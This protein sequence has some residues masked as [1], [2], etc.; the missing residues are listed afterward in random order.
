MGRRWGCVMLTQEFRMYAEQCRR[1]AE[2]VRTEEE[3]RVWGK[4]AILCARLAAEEDAALEHRR[5][6]G[7]LMRHHVRH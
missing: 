5:E 1:M 3:R 7:A 6:N 2:S 4:L